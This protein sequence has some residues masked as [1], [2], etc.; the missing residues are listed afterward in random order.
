MADETFLLNLRARR[1]GLVFNLVHKAVSNAA[2]LLKTSSFVVGM[3][4]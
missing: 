2:G 4:L 1:E 3:S